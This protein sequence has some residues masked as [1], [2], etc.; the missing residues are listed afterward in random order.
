MHS[1]LQDL[2][3]GLRQLYKSPSFTLTAI[4]TLAFGIGASTALFSVVDGVL[5]KPLTYRDSSRLVVIWERVRYL[6]KLSPYVGANPR[7]ADLWRR[8]SASFDDLTLV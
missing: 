5:L 4:L 7:H 6:E 1:I 3:Y 8:Q 2:R